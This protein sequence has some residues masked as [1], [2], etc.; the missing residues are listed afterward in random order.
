MISATIGSSP[1]EREGHFRG[2]TLVSTRV[3]QEGAAFV[4]AD[5]IL[6]DLFRRH[7]R[8]A[9]L[10]GCVDLYRLRCQTKG[11]LMPRLTPARCSVQI[12]QTRSA[13]GKLVARCP[14]AHLAPLGNFRCTSAIQT[15][16]LKVIGSNPIPATKLQALENMMFS[17]AF[18]YFKFGWKSR[19]WKRQ[20]ESRGAKSAEAET[21][22]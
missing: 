1:A 6:A 20:E 8:V 12:G 5:E 16:N 17:K 18:C 19:L 2:A 10:P 21:T 11:S 7:L 3:Y 9:Q 22:R 13:V 15:H 14:R 4:V